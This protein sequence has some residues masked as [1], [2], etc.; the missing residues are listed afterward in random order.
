MSI[1]LI[2]QQ[3]IQILSGKEYFL[4][5]TLCKVKV[6]TISG[7]IKIIKGSENTMIILPNS[8]TLH[9]KDALLSSRSKKN[10]FS[11]QDARCSG[12]HL[13]TLNADNIDSLCIISYK[14]GIKTI[15]EKLETSNWGLY[16]VPIRYI[17][18][19]ATMSWKLVNPDEFGL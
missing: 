2:V 11:F 7:L 18:S 17:K 5:L 4:N 1:L 3:H 10:L 6:Y 13:E 14:M 8:T 19:D 15:H 16:Y 12:Y 9:L